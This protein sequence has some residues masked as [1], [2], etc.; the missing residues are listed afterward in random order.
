MRAKRGGWNSMWI[1]GGGA[2]KAKKAR[3]TSRGLA[4]WRDEWAEEGWRQAGTLIAKIA[5]TI[6]D[7]AHILNV[8]ST[9][10]RAWSILGLIYSAMRVLSSP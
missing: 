2:G 7:L 10:S 8:E 5:F 6:L 9:V 1:G 4:K 3:M